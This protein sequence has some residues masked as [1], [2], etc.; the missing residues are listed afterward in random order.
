MDFT[1]FQEQVNDVKN[2]KIDD[3]YDEDVR[4]SDDSIDIDLEYLK[5]SKKTLEHQE[6]IGKNTNYSIVELSLFVFNY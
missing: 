1:I 4:L 5:F 2:L 3:E 6:Q